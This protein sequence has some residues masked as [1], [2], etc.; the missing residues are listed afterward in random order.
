MELSGDGMG[1][2]GASTSDYYL[3]LCFSQSQLEV[4]SE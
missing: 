3:E 1:G 4:E 2:G